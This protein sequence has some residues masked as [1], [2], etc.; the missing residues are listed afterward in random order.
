M[1]N[2]IT[3]RPD[4]RYRTKLYIMSNIITF[5][6]LFFIPIMLINA[7]GNFFV[8]ALIG[9]GTGF[10]LLQMIIWFFVNLYFNTIV[11][12]IKSDEIIVRAGF[13]TKTV[14]HVPFRN[15][16]NIT[17]TRDIFDQF[18]GIGSLSVQTAGSGTAIPEER[19]AGIIDLQTLY[20]H[21][22]GE[23]RRFRNTTNPNQSDSAKATPNEGRVLI[24]ILQELRAIRQEMNKA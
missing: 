1:K 17:T 10:V 18:L 14:K 21:V 4:K 15:I 9:C 20:N 12:E 3:I 19:L 11:Y 6:M 5:F 7:G 8:F 16:T 22:A 23:L 24:A 2:N 13:F